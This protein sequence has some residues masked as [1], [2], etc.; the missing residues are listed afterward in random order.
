MKFYLLIT[1]SL[2]LFGCDKN[3]IIKNDLEDL[4][5]ISQFSA[6]VESFYYDNKRLPK[7]IDELSN[8]I[9]DEEKVYFE[10]FIDSINK[11]IEISY[12]PIK[13]DVEMND[14]DSYVL[15][16]NVEKKL[17]PKKPQFEKDL[18]DFVSIC[19]HKNGKKGDIIL[20]YSSIYLFNYKSR[21]FDLEMSNIKYWKDR[22]NFYVEFQIDS[23]LNID[24]NL[25]FKIDFDKASIEG[26]LY[27]NHIKNLLKNP[28]FPV[29]LKGLKV[30]TNDNTFF[31]D[32]VIIVPNK[33]GY[34][35][36]ESFVD[37][38]GKVKIPYHLKG[39]R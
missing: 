22:I 4:T 5:E 39:C 37:D 12:I 32:N 35:F 23:S 2:I 27:S 36:S 29:M 15:L 18:I 34:N 16:G 33:S 11:K 7:S 21:P 13:S 26:Q 19:E 8:W 6:F 10:S 30:K 9:S 3:N 17:K 38:K 14:F 25:N 24:E 1:V 31:I 28:K 20:D